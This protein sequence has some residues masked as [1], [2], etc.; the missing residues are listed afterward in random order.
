MRTDVLWELVDVLLELWEVVDDALWEV[1][2]DVEV[3]VDAPPEMDKITADALKAFTSKTPSPKS[4]PKSFLNKKVKVSRF[5]DVIA[6]ETSSPVGVGCAS[7][8]TEHA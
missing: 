4:L 3:V 6:T 2:E 1:V 5:A 7:P 8:E